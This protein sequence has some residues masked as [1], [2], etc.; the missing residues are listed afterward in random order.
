MSDSL[1]LTAALLTHEA[2]IEIKGHRHEHGQ[3]SVVLAGT[4]TVTVQHGWWLIPPGL[5]IWIPPDEAH[6]AHYS[7]S[8]MLINLQ[9]DRAGTAG[10]PDIGMPLVVTDL[11]RELAY[12]ASRLSCNAQMSEPLQLIARLIAHQIRHP[13]P[14]PGLFVPGAKD[15]RL[16]VVIDFLRANPGSQANIEELAELAHTSSRTLARLFVDETHLTF[17]R[18]RDHVRVVSAVD[19]LTRGHGITRVALDLGYQSASSFSTLFTRL[20]GEPPRRYM[21][22]WDKIINP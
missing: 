6:S 12:E 15:R 13:L 3:L 1:E 14:S 4:M 18:W 2:G 20:L 19:R 22:R 17:G 10:L 7:E 9:F 8:S 21:K 16:R 5:A 11:L